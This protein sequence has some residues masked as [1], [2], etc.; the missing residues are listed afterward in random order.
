MIVKCGIE[1]LSTTAPSYAK[2]YPI[3][4]T[5]TANNILNFVSEGVQALFVSTKTQCYIKQWD[6]YYDAQLTHLLTDDE[7]TMELF[8]HQDP[9]NTHIS[10]VSDKPLNR[11]FYL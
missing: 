2:T 4:T 7:I 8:N 1:E 10:S 11:V 9:P 3:A 5:G 6:V